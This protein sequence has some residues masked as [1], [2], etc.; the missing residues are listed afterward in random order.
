MTNERVDIHRRVEGKLENARADPEE[1][2]S[3]PSETA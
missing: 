3:W 2:I 1:V